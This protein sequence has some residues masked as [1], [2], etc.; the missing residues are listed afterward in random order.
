MQRARRMSAIAKV[1]SKSL[2]R[3]AIKAA[4]HVKPMDMATQGFRSSS[5]NLPLAGVDAVAKVVEAIEMGG[6][7][8]LESAGSGVATEPCSEQGS[9]TQLS[10]S[11]SGLICSGWTLNNQ[12]LLMLYR[13]ITASMVMHSGTNSRSGSSRSGSSSSS[14]F[15][16]FLSSSPSSSSLSSRSP[17]WQAGAD[18]RG[19]DTTSVAA[20][21]PPVGTV[22][23]PPAPPPPPL[24]SSSAHRVRMSDMPPPSGPLPPSVP[25][26][27]ETPLSRI[28]KP[29]PTP[30]TAASST[31]A[32]PPPFLPRPPRFQPPQN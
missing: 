7:T 18:A 32:G 12:G 8:L 11:L 10:H 29:R 16:R 25:Q 23:S 26:A 14:D 22:L 15:R 3:G 30:A 4:I 17:P 19:A 24:F 27:L 20:L 21:P 1:F 6:R 5:L 2:E 9:T 13:V 31:P 28:Y